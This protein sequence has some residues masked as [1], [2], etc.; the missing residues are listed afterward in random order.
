MEKSLKHTQ[1]VDTATELFRRFGARRV[2]IEELCQKAGVSKVTFYKYFENKADLIRHIRDEMIEV[3]FSRFDEISVMEIPYPEKI[4][5]MTRWRVEFFSN[6]N[7]EFVRE[8]YMQDEV[9]EEA[10]RRFLQNTTDAQQK[11]EVRTDLSP[12]FIWFITEKLNGI[13]REGSWKAVF[14][15]YSTFQKQMRTLF[16][17]G[18]LTREGDDDV[19]GGQQ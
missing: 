5:L 12:E 13:I 1:I 15:E 14:D 10:K 11:G 9:V 18:L 8:L 4:D 16:F 6:M 7:E 17:Y 3:S 2:S 19:A